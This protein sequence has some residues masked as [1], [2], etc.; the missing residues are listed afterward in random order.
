MQKDSVIIIVQILLTCSIP[1][2]NIENTRVILPMYGNK[3]ENVIWPMYRIKSGNKITHIH[4][5]LY[6]ASFDQGYGEC[7][8]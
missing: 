6:P 3:S 4:F 8:G 5:R 7:D 1:R 2:L